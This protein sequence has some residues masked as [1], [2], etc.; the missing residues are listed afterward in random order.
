MDIAIIDDNDME[1]K[2]ITN[3]LR[4]F[5]EETQEEQIFQIVEFAT[6]EELLW[7]QGNIDLLF[8]DIEIGEVNG[9]ELAAEVRKRHSEK[10]IIVFISAYP[11]YVN[12]TYHAEAFGFLIK[13]VEKDRFYSEMHRCLRRYQD[14]QEAIIRLYYG[15]P[16]VINKSEIVYLE[17]HKR[18]IQ[19]FLSDGRCIEYYGKLSDELQELNNSHF[20]QC[21][22]GLIVNLAYIKGFTANKEII[23]N[24][25]SSDRR[26][27][28]N[29]PVSIPY[30]KLVE[31]AFLQYVAIYR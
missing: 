7:Y 9:T 8:M 10:M 18:I 3:Y 31:N 28:K 11:T 19:V 6:A 13:P 26:E 20:V 16:L 29:L 1:R 14:Q 17:V 27:W 4:T 22:R 30:R 2:I 21:H 24:L 5:K 15:E 23:L 25:K 12:K